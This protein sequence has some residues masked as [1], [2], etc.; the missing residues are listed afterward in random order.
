MRKYIVAVVGATGVVGQEMIQILESRDFPVKTL[1]PL[2]SERSIGKTVKFKG[3]Y[4]KV[5][6]CEKAAFEGVDFALFSA[7]SAVSKEFCPI[8][9]KQNVICVD[10]TSYFRMNPE[11][12]LVVPEVNAQVLKTHKGI[13]ANPNCSTAQL[14]MVLKPIHDADHEH[15]GR[16]L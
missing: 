4:H 9:A 13:I 8:A 14:V 6:L 16:Q 10:N 15:G 12:P 3:Q 7:G 5:A 11:V 1:R 2:A